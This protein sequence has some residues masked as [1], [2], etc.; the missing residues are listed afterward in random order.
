[1]EEIAIRKAWKERRQAREQAEVLI[2]SAVLYDRPDFDSEQIIYHQSR[3]IA[4]V[5]REMIELGEQYGFSE[6]TLRRAYKQ[7]GAPAKKES[8]DGP[9]IWQL[10]S[11]SGQE[12]STTQ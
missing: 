6:R 4:G 11:P 7:I 9:W 10:L 1:M 5:T 2:P 12:A 8:F 3:V